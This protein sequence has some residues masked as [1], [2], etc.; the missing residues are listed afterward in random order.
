MIFQPILE[1]IAN[2]VT[3]VMG[4]IGT[5][6]VLRP[7]DRGRHPT[8]GSG[9]GQPASGTVQWMWAHTQYIAFFVAVIGVLIAC[10]QMA[11]SQRGESAREILRSL[12]TLGVASLLA[13]GV[14]QALI[15]FGDEF[16]KCIVT[17][18]LIDDPNSPWKCEPGDLVGTGKSFGAAMTAMLAVSATAGPMGIGLVITIGVLAML[19][20]VIQVVLMVVRSAML[21]LLVGVLPIAAAATNT[22]MGRGWFK[23]IL[24]WL[25][26]FVLYK[27]VAAII[28]ATAIRLTSN[29]GGLQLRDRRRKPART[30]MN[31]VTGLTMLVLALFALPGLMRFIAPMVAATAGNGRRRA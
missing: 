21:I 27:P 26:A 16:S 23:R 10:I 1:A 7:D 11:Y 30:V 20:G 8:M 3:I 5:F 28:Y 31:M 12:I 9:P 22:E 14:T 17:T 24:G 29:N 4:T 13:V 19:A 2:A 18:S 25:F 15:E 6:W